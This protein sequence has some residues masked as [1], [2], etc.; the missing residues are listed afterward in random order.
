MLRAA[1]LTLSLL[2]A[3]ALAQSAQTYPD[4]PV[5]IKNGVGGLI[6]DTI[7]IGLGTAGQKFYALDLS[8]SPRQWKE[9]ASFPDPARDQAEAA[10]VGGKLYVF[11]GMGKATPDATS[12]VFN[13]VHVYD[14]ASNSWT[15]LNTRAPREVAGGVATAQGDR[16]ILFGGVN[17]NIFDGYFTDLAAAGTDKTKSDAVARAYFDQRPQDYFFGRDVEAYTPA[18]NS[19]QSLGTVPFQGRAGAALV[20]QNGTLTV[21]NGEIKPGLR[22]PTTQRGVLENGALTWNALPD[23]P[24]PAGGGA[25]EG[26][27]GAYAGTSHGAVLVA[28]GANFPGAQANFASG[29]LYAHEGL[30]KTW[31]SDVYALQDGQ[32][33][34][35]GQL[36]AP[37][38]YGLS[39]Q[40]GDELIV[41]GG[42]QAGGTPGTGVYS[43][44]LDGGALKVRD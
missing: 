5:G 25:Q 9:V 4:L 41:V 36:P 20:N 44:E 42:E 2:A 15:R 24:A 31:R 33:K 6:G 10:V 37:L 14:P 32:W 18:T 13:Q 16:I 27:A 11:G 26:V 19:W 43:I 22:S 3:P 35:V 7:Y 23:L 17:K 39:V 21:V 30:T 40:R 34:V 12:T 29:K 8:A 28:G 38:G 1:A